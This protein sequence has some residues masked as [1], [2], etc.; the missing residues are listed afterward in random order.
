MTTHVDGDDYTWQTGAVR[1]AAVFNPE[2][3]PGTAAAW[4]ERWQGYSAGPDLRTADQV[5]RDDIAALREMTVA[6]ARVLEARI[7]TLEETVELLL[8][9]LEASVVAGGNGDSHK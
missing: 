2:A 3:Q 6:L 4:V 5:E 7:E 1:G 8:G 9:V